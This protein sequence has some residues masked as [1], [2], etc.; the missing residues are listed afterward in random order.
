MIWVQTIFNGVFL[1]ALY[2]LLGLGLALV[3]GVVRIVNIA[4]GEFIVLTAF[5][6]LGL[7]DL[8]PGV[9]PLIMLVPVV[10]IAAGGGYLLQAVLF[11]RVVKSPD[12]TVPMLFAFGLSFALRNGMVEAFGMD[13]QTLASGGLSSAGISIGE[14]SIGVLPAITLLISVGLFAAAQFV[15]SRTEL[16]RIIRATVDNREV[17]RLMGVRPD[18]IYNTVM[19]LSL[20]LAGVAGVLLAMR[21]TF[22]PFSGTERLL[23]SFEVVVLGGL[24]SFWGA[25]I[26]GIALGVVQLVGLRFDPNS[27]LLYPHLLFFAGLLFRP[28]GLFGAR[29]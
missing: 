18:R 29:A 14:L 19:A 27:G 5:L 2:G 25:L 11:N 12:P 22:T 6:A 8:F 21:S 3:F 10:A 13:P 24:G 26:A 15:M 28:N 17:V 9:P 20:A 4:H 1:G 7:A 23:V 16:G